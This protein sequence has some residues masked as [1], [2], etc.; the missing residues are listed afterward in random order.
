[1]FEA[2]LM[3]HDDWVFSVE[4]QRPHM[5]TTADG[6]ERF[7]QPMRLISASSDKSMMIWSP[8][9]DTGV[10]VNDVRMGDIGGSTYLGFCGALFSPDGKSIVSHGANGSFHFWRD[11]SEAKGESHW[12]PQVA[13]SGHF[14]SVESITWDPKSRFLISARYIILHT[15]NKLE[16]Y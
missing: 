9:A 8:D 11:Q 2:L 12:T 4:W 10:W 13:I 5:Q 3:G 15:R 6:T 1:M 7:V 16:S 14:K